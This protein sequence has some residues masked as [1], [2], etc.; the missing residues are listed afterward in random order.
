[1]IRRE[2][3]TTETFFLDGSNAERKTGLTITTMTASVEHG[4]S[5]TINT[6]SYDGTEKLLSYQ[7][8]FPRD[9]ESWVKIVTTFDSSNEQY[10]TRERF[11]TRDIVLPLDYV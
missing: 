2:K 4:S 5:V 1:M 8:N 6:Q 10:V 9:G 3:D 7:L 11:I